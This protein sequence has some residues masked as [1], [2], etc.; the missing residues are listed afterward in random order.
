MADSVWDVSR[1][2]FDPDVVAETAANL[3]IKTEET[4]LDL[5]NEK[6]EVLKTVKF[7]KVL[8]DAP[9]YENDTPED[10]FQRATAFFETLQPAVKDENGSVKRQNNPLDILCSHVAYSLDLTLRNSI[11][12][13]ETAVLAGPDKEI[14]RASA[15]LAAHLKITLDEARVRVRTA[16]G[17]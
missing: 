14:E 17:M 4:S 13:R 11:R 9:V 10:R 2:G 7:V 12:A 3:G 8:F 6:K 15:K 1:Q 16:W 5:K